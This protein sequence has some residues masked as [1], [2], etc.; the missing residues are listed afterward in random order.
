RCTVHKLRNL[1]S[2][3]PQHVH[4]ELRED[5]H[6]IVY[7]EDRAAARRARDAFLRKWSQRCPA[8]ATSLHEAGEELL[9]FFGFPASQWLSLRTTNAVERL[10]LEFRRRVKTQG[11]LPSETAALRLLFGLV[12]SGQIRLRRIKGFR[13]LEEKR[14]AEKTEAA[15]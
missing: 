7:A 12:A 6:R 13:D 9:T 10:Q 2:K 11:A 15:A 14:E 4:A 5:Y 8:V 1:E 3:A